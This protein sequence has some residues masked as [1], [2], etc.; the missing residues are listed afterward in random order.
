M[1]W[2]FFSSSWD[3]KWDLMG[4]CRTIHC[5]WRFLAWKINRPGFVEGEPPFGILHSWSFWRMVYGC[6]WHWLNPRLGETVVFLN[7][8]STVS[9]YGGGIFPWPWEGRKDETEHPSHRPA[10]RPMSL[11]IDWWQLCPSGLVCQTWQSFCHC[12]LLRRP[13]DDVPFGKPPF[14]A[15]KGNTH[16]ACFR[17][18]RPIHDRYFWSYGLSSLALP[19]EYKSSAAALTSMLP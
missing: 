5:T 19:A 2:C 1:W 3:S 15:F 14:F 13:P 7:S 8:S 16:S 10:T 6:L 9:K 11:Q 4:T 18:S 17:L 12:R